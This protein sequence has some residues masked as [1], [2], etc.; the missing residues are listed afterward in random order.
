MIVQTSEMCTSHLVHIWK[1][2]SHFWRVFNLDMYLYFSLNLSMS[3]DP[4]QASLLH[5]NTDPER[6]SFQTK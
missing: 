5:W 1:I 2:Y 3:M 4:N 6:Y